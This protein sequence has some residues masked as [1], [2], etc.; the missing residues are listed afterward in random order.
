MFLEGGGKYQLESRGDT[1]LLCAD[2]TEFRTDRYSN[3]Q[4]LAVNS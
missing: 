3:A 1:V 2:G 4:N